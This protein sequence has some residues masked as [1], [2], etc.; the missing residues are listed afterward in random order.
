MCPQL[1]Y[2]KVF[3]RRHKFVIEKH[4]VK[5]LARWIDKSLKDSS[6]IIARCMLVETGYKRFVYHYE[7]M[8]YF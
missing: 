6:I 8:L 3:T 2:Y 4:E 1:I 7:K 5:R